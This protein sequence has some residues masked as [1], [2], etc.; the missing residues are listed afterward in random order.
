[1]LGPNRPMFESFLTI[2][3]VVQH[4]LTSPCVFGALWDARGGG[5]GKK[6]RNTLLELLGRLEPNRLICG[7]VLGIGWRKHVSEKE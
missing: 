2:E 7:H 4:I 6:E 3:G 1:M 5:E